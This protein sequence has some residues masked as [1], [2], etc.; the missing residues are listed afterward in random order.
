MHGDQM[1]TGIMDFENES[2]CQRGWS[3]YNKDP[4]SNATTCTVYHHR[5]VFEHVQ[6]AMQLHQR[7]S[8]HLLKGY[9]AHLSL[10]KPRV[11]Q[12]SSFGGYKG[13]HFFEPPIETIKS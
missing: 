11:I 6:M 5:F 10:A 12:M 3:S 9:L 8:P 1:C 2:L 13:F 4:N 7:G